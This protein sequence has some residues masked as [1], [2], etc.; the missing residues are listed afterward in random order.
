M[1]ESVL[2]ESGNDRQKF[3][4]MEK[5]KVLSRDSEN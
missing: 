3:T 2:E 1:T 4:L 5:I